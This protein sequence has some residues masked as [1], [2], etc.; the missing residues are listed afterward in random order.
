MWRVSIATLLAS[1]AALG[2]TALTITF[3]AASGFGAPGDPL[4]SL[5]AT[6]IG[7]IR[8]LSGVIVANPVGPGIQMASQVEGEALEFRLPE[9]SWR[10]VLT[11]VNLT[12][13]DRWLQYIT[14]EDDGYYVNDFG[15]FMPASS[16][17]EYPHE[18]VLAPEPHPPFPQVGGVAF[19]GASLEFEDPSRCNLNAPDRQDCTTEWGL[20]SLTILT[21]S[22][23]DPV[24]EPGTALLVALGLLGLGAG[25]P[26]ARAAP[27]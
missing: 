21:E 9:G 13:E 7:D 16:F 4:P 12:A 27:P 19:L 17:V 5:Y 26:R 15:A 20:H 23:M 8:F 3:D 6:P 11:L 18:Q 25:R 1:L 24:P 22:G 14:T 10:V 2:A